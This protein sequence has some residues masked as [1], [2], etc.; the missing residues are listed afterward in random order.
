MPPSPPASFPTLAPP[1]TTTG[2]LAHLPRAKFLSPP[3]SRVV[4]SS[5]PRY[6]TVPPPSATGALAHLPRAKFLSLPLAYLA[7]A[8]EAVFNPHGMG[9]GGGG[10][11][12]VA[13]RAAAVHAPAYTIA[14]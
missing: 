3:V 2:A 7:D 4:L 13:S 1:C 8:D 10:A 14:Y 5:T 11:A 9:G 12:E 6:R